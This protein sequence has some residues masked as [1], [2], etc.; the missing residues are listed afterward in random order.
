M[1]TCLDSPDHAS[2]HYKY[3][4]FGSF[5]ISEGNGI[6]KIPTVVVIYVTTTPFCKHYFKDCI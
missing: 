5:P 4:A 6:L 2:L 3:L 1:L